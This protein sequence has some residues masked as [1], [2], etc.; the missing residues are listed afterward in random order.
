MRRLLSTFCLLLG[1]S[2]ASYAGFITSIGSTIGA[3][4]DLAGANA[5]LQDFNNTTT[6][7]LSA[8]TALT[9][10]NMSGGTTNTNVG[11]AASN[12][13]A[14]SGPNTGNQARISNSSAAIYGVSSVA[15][16]GSFSGN[17]I[18]TYSGGPVGTSS[19]F[20]RTLTITFSN[21]VFAFLID[22]ADNNAIQ[23]TSVVQING[24][25]GASQSSLVNQNCSV[26]GTPACAGSGRQIG[27]VAD[28][29]NPSISTVTF[30]FTGFDQAT[31][32]A[33]DFVT[34][35]NLRVAGSGLNGGG[36]NGDGGN[37]N[38]GGEIPEP[39][40]YTLLGAGLLSL[41]YARHRK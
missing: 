20:A 17:S 24:G 25:T 37:N 2:V 19:N 35:D 36:G 28:A 12:G 14:T 38:G 4:S 29:T 33:G 32:Y 34:F 21:P 41:A 18:Q 10:F 27:Y 3:G 39:S 13:G 23:G 26:V 5:V 31:G 40:T 15:G 9:S 11:I 16:V 8:F 7:P 6:F 22:Y 30:T 1:A